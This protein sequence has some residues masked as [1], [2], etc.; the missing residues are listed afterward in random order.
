MDDTKYLWLYKVPGRAKR[1]RFL[2][3]VERVV[4]T[5]EITTAPRLFS[6]WVQMTATFREADKVLAI[7]SKMLGHE[8]EGGRI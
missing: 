3:E 4:P 1:R 7:A 6:R 2:A 8:L 5:V